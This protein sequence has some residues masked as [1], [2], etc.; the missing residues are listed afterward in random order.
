MSLPSATLPVLVDKP[1]VLSQVKR[2]ASVKPRWQT[3]L[4]GEFQEGAHT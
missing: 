2:M 4:L 3:R 1:A